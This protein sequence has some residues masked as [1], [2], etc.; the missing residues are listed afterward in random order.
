MELKIFVLTENELSHCF[1]YFSY[2]MKTFQSI[3]CI[4]N[5]IYQACSLSKITD[6]SGCSKLC[7]GTIYPSM[8]RKREIE[9]SVKDKAKTKVGNENEFLQRESEKTEKKRCKR[10]TKPKKDQVF[11]SI[12]EQEQNH[13]MTKQISDLTLLL[14]FRLQCVHVH[15]TAI[16]IQLGR[17]FS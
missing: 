14:L 5:C 15:V 1:P 12:A 13:L 16:Q 7:F 10:K 4:I 3:W 9:I 11:E 2:S 6:K 8:K 17:N